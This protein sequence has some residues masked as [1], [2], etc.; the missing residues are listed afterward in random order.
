MGCAFET[1][2]CGGAYCVPDTLEPP[3]FA[4]GGT[5][6]ASCEAAGCTF[7]MT[8][9]IDDVEQ[10]CHCGEAFPTCL[11]FPQPA[12]SVPTVTAYYHE[13]MIGDVRL[14]PATWSTPPWPW[15]LCAGD[16]DAPPACSCADECGG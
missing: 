13:F 14:F 10:K 11:W 8:P 5:D 7:V 3:P 2:D 12:D 16:P 1:D 9:W 15:K 6:Q 4:C